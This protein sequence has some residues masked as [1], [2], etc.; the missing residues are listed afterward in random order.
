[1]P[2]EWEY[3]QGRSIYQ[4]AAQELRDTLTQIITTYKLNEERYEM[5]EETT[6]HVT[7]S[8]YTT[9]FYLYNCVNL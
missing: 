4:L 1:V 5:N 2:W 3:D 9:T 8:M 7:I 6:R